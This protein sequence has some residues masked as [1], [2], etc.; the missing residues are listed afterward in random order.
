MNVPQ[1]GLEVHEALQ[2]LLILFFK[3]LECGARPL[4][5]RIRLLGRNL[6]HVRPS[7]CVLG[8]LLDWLG[9]LIRYYFSITFLGALF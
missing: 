8:P 5:L 7:C 3:V 9:A 6:A 4:F 1:P 2:S